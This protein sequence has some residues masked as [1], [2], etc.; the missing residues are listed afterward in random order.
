MD[1]LLHLA[2]GVLGLAVILAIAYIFSNNRQRMDWRMI[3]IGLLLQVV[4]AVFLL[5]GQILGEVFAPLGWPKAVF[6]WVSSQVVLLLTFTTEGAMFV[7]G[8]L[9]RPPMDSIPPGTPLETGQSWGSSIAFQVLPTI[10]FFGS[11]MAILYHLGIMQRVIQAMAYI[12]RRLMRTSGA[13]SLAVT[14]NIFIGQSEAPLAIRPYLERMTTSELMAVMTGG[15]ATIAGGVLAAYVVFLGAP[16][17]AA[18][19]IAIDVAQLRFA[20]HLLSASV[21]A[22]PAALIIA[23]ILI[24]ETGAPETGGSVKAAI[25]APSKNIIDAAAAGAEDG[26]KLMLNV[27]AMLIAFLA[28]I[29]LLDYILG[30]GGNL[31]GVNL[32]MGR[33]LGWMF[34]PLAWLIGV[35]WVDAAQF[36]ALLGTK[37]VATEFVAYLELAGNIT[38]G[39]LQPKT[40]IMATF[41]LCG[42]ANFASIA[43]QIGGI[44]P[45]APS[46][47]SELAQLGLKAV[48]A[49]TLANLMTATIVGVLMS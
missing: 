31:V 19:N 29:A 22:A 48:L 25:D 40:V 1:F 10:I 13:E 45:L 36:G 4:L 15:M 28:L 7:F 9:A 6:S 32:S 27:G 2:R 41:A 21:M 39:A 34:A 24:P 30:W 12:V 23:K 26:L 33:L 49:G 8:D 46:R 35:P 42:F 11:L 47:K 43:I 18:H 16:Y 44:G 5:K 37:V 14:A 17:A 38:H 3:G 20:E